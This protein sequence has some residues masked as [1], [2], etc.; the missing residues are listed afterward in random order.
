[1]SGK[2][3]GK[4]SVQDSNQLKS[5]V[6]RRDY[7]SQMRTIADRGFLTDDERLVVLDRLKTDLEQIDNLY[8]R[9]WD[10]IIQK[11]NLEKGENPEFRLEFETG[12]IYIM[13]NTD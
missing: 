6:L 11:Y 4:V 1:M 13:D 8:N 3:L 2:L 7:L 12:N 10:E 5:I 9:V